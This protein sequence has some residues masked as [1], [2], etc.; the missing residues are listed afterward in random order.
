MTMKLR[1]DQIPGWFNFE[2]IYQEA[3]DRAPQE[4]SH[5]VE[6]GVL[7][8]RSTFF[9]A[10]AIARSGKSIAFDAVDNFDYGPDS[11]SAVLKK[12]AEKCSENDLSLLPSLSLAVNTRPIL[13]IVRKHADL[14]GLGHLVNLVRSRGQDLAK[15]YPDE[16]LDFVFIDS[17]HTYEDTRSMLEAYLPKLRRGGVLAGHDHHTQY[18]GVIQAVREA[19]GEVEVRCI[20]FI[21][22]K[23]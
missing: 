10:D 5:F 2:D 6:I 3:V 23:Q 9:M 4:G 8:G 17:A 1:W 13:E 11:L 12:Y 15:S 20:S 21:W 18:P 14:S 7:F 16:G 22:R 19:L